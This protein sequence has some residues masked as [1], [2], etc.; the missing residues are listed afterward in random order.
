MRKRGR[1]VSAKN[2]FSA[3]VLILLVSACAAEASMSANTKSGVNGSA[4]ASGND[5]PPQA[6]AAAAPAPAPAPDP[7]PSAAPAILPGCALVCVNA[8]PRLRVNADTESKIASAVSSEMSQLHNCTHGGPA[9]SLTLRFDSAG[10][11]TEFGIDDEHSRN[12]RG[13]VESVRS[14]RPALS[15]PGPATLRCSERCDRRHQQQQQQQRRY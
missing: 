11:L 12:E 2:V 6:P 14:H 8:H 5:D 15:F 10:E 7:A 3:G 1:T 13:C 4:S 9:P